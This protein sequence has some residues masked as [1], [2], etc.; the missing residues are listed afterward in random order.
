MSHVHVVAEKSLKTVMVQLDNRDIRRNKK[1]I[2]IS[3]VRNELDRTAGKLKDF[4]GSL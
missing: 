1:M 3:V 2:E 4:R